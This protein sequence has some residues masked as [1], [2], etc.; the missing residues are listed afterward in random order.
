VLKKQQNKPLPIPTSQLIL[1]RLASVRIAVSA[2]ASCAK[3]AWLQE[4]DFDL[5]S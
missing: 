4:V 1:L 5:A 3:S 2:P